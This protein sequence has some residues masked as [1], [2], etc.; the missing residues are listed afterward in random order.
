MRPKTTNNYH[1]KEPLNYSSSVRKTS[2][3]ERY[4][5]LKKFLSLCLQYLYK[6]VNFL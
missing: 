5:S 6:L 4:M 3:N 2:K 1:F